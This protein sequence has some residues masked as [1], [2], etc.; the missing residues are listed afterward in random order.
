MVSTNVRTNNEAIKICFTLD[1]PPSGVSTIRGN[2]SY[3][4]P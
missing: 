4:S 2:M 1:N 3:D